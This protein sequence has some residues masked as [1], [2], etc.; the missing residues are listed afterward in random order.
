[1]E[2]KSQRQI[3]Q[4]FDSKTKKMREMTTGVKLKIS[5]TVKDSE[6]DL[7]QIQVLE[8][9]IQNKNAAIEQRR[10]AVMEE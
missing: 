6:M 2:S 7:K 9:Q 3:V 1:M 10:I 4:E 5:L 8:K